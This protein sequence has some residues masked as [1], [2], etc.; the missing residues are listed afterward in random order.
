MARHMAVKR[1]TAKDRDQ[2]FWSDTALSRDAF[3]QHSM[4]EPEI[5]ACGDAL[6][7]DEMCSVL[8]PREHALGGLLAAF[9]DL[10]LRHC[11]AQNCADGT[12]LQIVAFGDFADEVA[13][14]GTIEIETS[15]WLRCGAGIGGRQL[16][17]RC[18]QQQSP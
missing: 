17:E 10:Y 16:H 14:V 3:E 18:E 13:D 5:N 15:R 6:R 2:I 8:P 4:L 11:M 7:G 9:D 1:F 12:R